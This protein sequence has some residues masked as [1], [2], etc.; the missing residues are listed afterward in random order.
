MSTSKEQLF[1]LL[2]DLDIKTTLYTHEP[3]YTV[4]QSHG[5]YNELG[6]PGGRCK[7]LFLKDSKKRLYLLVALADTPIALKILSKTIGAPELRFTDAQLLQDT[8]GVQPGSVTPFGLINDL[9]HKVTVILDTELFTQSLLNFHPLS[10]DATV[11]ITPGDLKKFIASCGNNSMVYNF[12][13]L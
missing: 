10:N 9:E 12:R 6:V 7:N 3:L 8:L 1:K 2:T 4:E 11:T 13:E 5:V